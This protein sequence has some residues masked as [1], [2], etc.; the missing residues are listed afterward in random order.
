MNSGGVDNTVTATGTPDFGP[1][2]TV[3]DIS[4]D[5]IDTDG[6]TTDDPTEFRFAPS[7]IDS[8]VSLE[9]TTTSNIVR[10]GDIVP[11]EITVTNVNTF[12]VGP[13]DLVDTLPPGFLYVPDS[14]SL[15]GAVSTGRRITWPGIT[16]PAA[17]SLT[18]T[19]EARI[20]NGARSGDLVNTVELFDS[21][22]GAP[23]ASPATATVRMLPEPVFDCGD[24]I[25]KVFEDHNGNGDRT[26]KLR[27][28]SPI[29]TSS[30]AS[31][32]ARRRPQCLRRTWLKTACRTRVWRR[33]TARSS[34]RTRTACS[35][36]LAPCCLRI[37]ARTSS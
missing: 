24:V 26:P 12:L 13:V 23:V 6:N 35:R 18:V 7:I 8:G 37:V 33:W 4:D 5:G 3:S 25:G 31:S 28:R 14:S 11:Y 36:C 22:T 30:T 29:R 16:I 17:S 15:A 19:I 21:T 34:R 32:A 9:K 27:A 20:L 10:R 2:P 1:D